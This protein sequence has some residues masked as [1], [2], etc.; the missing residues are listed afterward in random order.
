MPHGAYVTVE[1]LS[2]FLYTKDVTWGYIDDINNF[3][4]REWKSRSSLLVM[5]KKRKTESR[6]KTIAG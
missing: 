3:C 2:A 6:Q 4:M 1:K 5:K